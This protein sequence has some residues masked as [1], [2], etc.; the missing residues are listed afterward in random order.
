MDL[1]KRRIILDYAWTSKS[2]CQSTIVV[3]YKSGTLAFSFEKFIVLLLLMDEWIRIRGKNKLW[4]IMTSTSKYSLQNLHLENSHKQHLLSI[5]AYVKCMHNLTLN[6]CEYKSSYLRCCSQKN[7]LG[8]SEIQVII[9]LLQRQFHHQSE[10]FI[11]L[12]QP[13]R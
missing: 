2:Y 8:I 10:V 9:W 5:L 12:I 3:L 6:E 4:N 7:L 11:V 13:S 1:G